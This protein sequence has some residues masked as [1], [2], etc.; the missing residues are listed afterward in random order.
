MEINKNIYIFVWHPD[1][2]FSKI[3]QSLSRTYMG[4]TV[5]AFVRLEWIFNMTFFH[6]FELWFYFE[7]VCD[8]S[9]C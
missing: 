3:R 7:I 6:H 9:L 8:I 2:N 4:T 1:Q 5:T